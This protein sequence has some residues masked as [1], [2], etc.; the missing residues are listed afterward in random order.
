MT[1]NSRA[2]SASRLGPNA[3]TSFARRGNAIAVRILVTLTPFDIHTDN[4]SVKC[5]G[6]HSYF[7]TQS[8]ELLQGSK[9][10][11]AA[12]D[13]LR[14]SIEIYN[15]PTGR[16]F[17][18]PREGLPKA[19]SE[20]KKGPHTGQ[21]YG[22]QNALPS[23]AME[24]WQPKQ[25][26]NFVKNQGPPTRPE[27]TQ[28]TTIV[29]SNNPFGRYFPAE[30]SKFIPNWE[31]FQALW[32]PQKE[33]SNLDEGQSNLQVSTPILSLGEITDSLGGP[34]DRW[35]DEVTPTYYR[36]L[37]KQDKTRS[38]LCL[39]LFDTLPGLSCLVLIIC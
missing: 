5:F 14:L 8:Q 33:E 26:L 17:P 27:I 24:K 29:E 21:K 34:L 37:Y 25:Y 30:E 39:V 22:F 6:I 18:M 13:K 19:R 7:A 9:A 16:D 35:S 23:W 38:R 1:T 2:N 20:I 36:L 15:D 4:A 28:F 10:F 3:N 11:V 12:A 31:Q 32:D